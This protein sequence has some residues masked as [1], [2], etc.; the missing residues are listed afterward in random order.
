M[1]RRVCVPL[2]YGVI[3]VCDNY[4]IVSFICMKQIEESNVLSQLGSRRIGLLGELA[5]TAR[6]KFVS[7]FY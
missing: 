7:G 4:H 6:P 1:D 3:F 2:S 5:G